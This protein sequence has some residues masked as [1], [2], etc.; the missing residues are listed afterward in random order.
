MKTIK[1]F[2]RELLSWGDTNLAKTPKNDLD[3]GNGIPKTSVLPPGRVSQPSTLEQYFPN[4]EGIEIIKPEWYTDLIPGIRTLAYSNPNMSQSLNNIV[5]LG[6]TGHDIKFD[7][8]VPAEQIVAMKQHLDAVRKSW[9]ASKA[10]ADG[11]VD[12]MMRQIMIGGALSVEWVPRDDLKGIKQVALVNPETVRWA[13]DRRKNIYKPYQTNIGIIIPNNTDNLIELNSHT[14]TYYA[15]NG[16]TDIPYGIPPYIAALDGLKTQRVMMDNIKFIMEQ[17]GIAGFLEMMIDKPDKLGTESEEKY[18]E[19]LILFLQQAKERAKQGFRD[20]ISVGYK[21]DVEYKFN[22]TSKSFQ[23]VTEFFNLNEQ[24]FSSGLNMDGS[25]LGRSFGSSETQISIVFTKLLSQLKTIQQLVATCLEYGYSL[26]L[27]LAGFKFKTLKVEFKPSTALDEL[28][29]EQAQEIRIRNANQ[30]YIDGIISQEQYAH[31]VG[32][33]MPNKKAPR[34]IATSLE[35]PQDAA[36]RRK[37]E[38]AKKNENDKNIRRKNK[39]Q[40]IKEKK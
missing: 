13:Y 21:D 17:V 4:T 27:M 18:Q 25:M 33:E 36:A 3:S 9:T 11:L 35:T 16:D 14:F 40:D 8:S 29:H 15:L 37:N 20:G 30:L 5:E 31:R 10:S 23:G 19:R 2:G 12:R 7:P 26:E 22:S 38:N 39:P 1:L 6:N 32:Y 34:F 28:K 24:L